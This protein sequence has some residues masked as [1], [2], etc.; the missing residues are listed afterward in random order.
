VVFVAAELANA[1]EENTPII[2]T[3]ESNAT[4]RATRRSGPLFE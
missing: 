2:N 4:D 3:P 1:G